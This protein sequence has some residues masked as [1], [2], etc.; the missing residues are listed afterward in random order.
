MPE[1]SRVSDAERDRAINALSD[2][3][4]SGRLSQETFLRRLD[5]ALRARNRRE[6]SDL[7]GDLPAQG[8]FARRLINTVE[9]LSDLRGRIRAAW[10]EPQLPRLRM[11]APAPYPLRIGRAPGCELLLSD[12][13]VSRRHAELL[14]LDGE[15]VL[16]D[17]RSTNG[18]TVNGWRITSEV[19]VRPGDHVSF[20]NLDFR[21]GA[22]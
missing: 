10:R 4:S 1:A 14:H 18:T 9:Q 22:R 20:G 17:L 12:A 3:V 5:A 2:H 8:H 21:L 6:L 15:W 16:R 7:T 19:V 13:S 11:P